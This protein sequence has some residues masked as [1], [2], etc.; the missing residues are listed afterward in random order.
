LGVWAVAG[1]DSGAPTNAASR[2]DRK[3]ASADLFIHRGKLAGAR[4]E[5]HRE[6]ERFHKRHRPRAA[7]K[8]ATHLP[9]Q[10]RPHHALSTKRRQTGILMDVHP[11]LRGTLKRRN[12]SFLGPN[13]MNNLLEAHN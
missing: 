4:A 12:S 8:R 10:D 11:V 9:A 3:G 5:Q 2:N 6:V 7:L 1:T 13:R